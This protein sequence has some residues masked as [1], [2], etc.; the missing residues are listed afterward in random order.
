MQFLFFC[1]C[2]LSQT[3][4]AKN[5]HLPKGMFFLGGAGTLAAPPLV[6]GSRGDPSLRWTW[7]I[8]RCSFC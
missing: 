4:Q 8:F 2:S 5:R 7:N 3:G 1:L 6:D